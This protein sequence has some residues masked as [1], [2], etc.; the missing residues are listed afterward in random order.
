MTIWRSHIKIVGSVGRSRI[1]LCLNKSV[2]AMG[3]SLNDRHLEE[4]HFNETDKQKIRE[5][6]SGIKSYDDYAALIKEWKV[7]GGSVDDNVRRLYEQVKPDDIVWIRDRGIYYMGRVGE[8]SQWEYDSSQELLDRDSTTQRTDIEW[9][10]VGDESTVP[11][12]V[13]IAF[14]RGK[15]LQRIN[16]KAVET[17]S[18][19]YYNTIIGKEHYQGLAV[20]ADKETLYSL[21]SPTDC[22]DLVCSYLFSKYGYVVIPSTNKKS[23]E[24]YECVLLNQKDRTHVYI[25][26]KSGNVDI[27]ANEYAD[28]EGEVFLFTSKGFVKNLDSAKDNIKC[29]KPEDLFDFA[30]SDEAKN[31]VSDAISYWTEYMRREPK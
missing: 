23:T 14:I 19:H 4:N 31:I 2:L 15:T 22:E 11:G 1:E 27:D 5:Q 13:A 3:W 6:R 30:M 8:N 10:K 12:F 9:I 24:L 16:S 18:Q 28:L 7:Y 17:F 21:L 20:K 26:V 29:I 25:Q